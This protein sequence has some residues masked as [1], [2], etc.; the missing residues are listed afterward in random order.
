MT[1]DQAEQA[2]KLQGIKLTVIRVTGEYRVAPLGLD[3]EFE[4]ARAYYTDDLDDAYNT[5]LCMAAEGKR[6][7]LYEGGK[8]VL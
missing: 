6:R 2:L 1:I 4:E 8:G 7:Q 5:G 3:P